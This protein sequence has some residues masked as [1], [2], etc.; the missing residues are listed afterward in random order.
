[1]TE[2]SEVHTRDGVLK[3]VCI[4]AYAVPGATAAARVESPSGVE[5]VAVDAAADTTC[6][7][8]EA[9]RRSSDTRTGTRRLI[10]VPPHRWGGPA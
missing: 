6:P 4:V 1:M 3:R 5:E 8:Q 7:T 2:S 10:A 9:S